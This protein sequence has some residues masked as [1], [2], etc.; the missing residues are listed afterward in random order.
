[1]SAPAAFAPLYGMLTDRFDVTWIVGVDTRKAASGTR[2]SCDECLQLC[3]EI[4]S[5]EPPMLRR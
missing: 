3:E 2:I 4:L 1:L 5:D